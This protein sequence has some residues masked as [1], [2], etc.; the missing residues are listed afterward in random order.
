MKAPTF[1]FLLL[2]ASNVSAQSAS[3]PSA[4]VTITISEGSPEYCVGEGA[5]P[6]L[7]KAGPEDIT[8]RLPMKV[9]YENHRTETIILPLWSHYLM[10]MTVD[11]QNGSTDLRNATRGLLD[12]K[13]VMALSAPDSLFTIIAGGKYVWSTA[14]EAVAIPVLRLSSG[15]DLRGKTV[16]LL[17]TREFRT[18]APDVVKALNEKW[19]DYGT[20]WT[21]VAES[22]S[23]IFNIPP[24]PLTRGSCN[25]Q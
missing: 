23:L 24:E 13:G 11:G 3:A 21:G 9:A 15:L 10:R 5:S 22:N 19:K 1:L 4:D 25:P 18:L 7:P 6:L 20:V 12:V 2:A 14:L 17:M 16:H 8:L